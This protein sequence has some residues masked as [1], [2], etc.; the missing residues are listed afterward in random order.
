MDKYN[1]LS[2][3][4]GLFSVLEIQQWTWLTSMLPWK[5]IQLST[6]RQTINKSI[7]TVISEHDK[8]YEGLS[9]VGGDFRKS[10]LGNFYERRK[11]VNWDSCSWRGN[12]GSTNS[13]SRFNK[14]LGW[15]CWYDKW[16][17]L[18]MGQLFLHF[19]RELLFTIF[20]WFYIRFAFITDL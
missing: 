10:S 13:V 20:A 15:K 4:Q 18:I 14:F 5:T 12:E 11:C 7:N 8:C 1:F 2:L 16:L 19:F 9:R 3:S 17:R 6:E